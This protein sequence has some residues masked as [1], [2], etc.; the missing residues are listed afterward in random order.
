MTL[1][2]FNAANGGS[3]ESRPDIEQILKSTGTPQQGG[4]LIDFHNDMKDSLP[5][6][7]AKKLKRND[8]DDS[9]DEFV[10]AEG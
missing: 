1:S 2:E 5:A 4:A 10:D 3:S 7:G 9:V 8:T 6:G